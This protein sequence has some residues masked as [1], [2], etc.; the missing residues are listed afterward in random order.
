[1]GTGSPHSNWAKSERAVV[2][3]LLEQA[4]PDAPTLC[5]EWTTRDLAAHLV[6]REKRP[7]ASLGIVVSQAAGW[8]ERVQDGEAQRPY[9]ELVADVKNGPPKLSFFSLP[10]ID[11]MFNI[12]EY[13]VHAE[14]IRRAGENPAG[15]R[16]LPAEFSDTLWKLV[17]KRGPAFFRRSSVGVEV[18]RTDGAQ[19]T[20]TV[21]SGEPSITIRGTAPELLLYAYGRKQVADVELVGD[22]AALKQFEQTDLSV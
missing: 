21:H 16:E 12:A 7:D 3:E 9:E 13:F 19:E 17:S 1:M 5:G 2:A 6:V 11:S 15:P 4:G 8:T 22:D 18:Q 20:S 10:N 14:D